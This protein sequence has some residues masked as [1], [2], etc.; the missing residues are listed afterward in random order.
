MELKKKYGAA[1]LKFELAPRDERF[2]VY[3]MTR[4]EL[5]NQGSRDRAGRLEQR[6]AS[7]CGGKTV[8]RR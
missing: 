1:G 8:E 6:T 4:N 7:D 2:A 3:T 5:Q